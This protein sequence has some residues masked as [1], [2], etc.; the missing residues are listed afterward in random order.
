MTALTFHL[1]Q[2]KNKLPQPCTKEQRPGRLN[3]FISHLT[4]YYNTYCNNAD[5]HIVI[6]PEYSLYGHSIDGSISICQQEWKKLKSTLSQSLTRKNCV[7]IIGTVMRRKKVV[8]HFTELK[9]KIVDLNNF[10][11]ENNNYICLVENHELELLQRNITIEEQR[12]K[13]NNKIP[14]EFHR[15]DRYIKHYES[16]KGTYYKCNVMNLNI[17]NEIQYIEKGL[18]TLKTKPDSQMVLNTALC[19][20]PTGIYKYNKITNFNEV[21]NTDNLLYMPGSILQHYNMLNCFDNTF[22]ASLEICMDHSSNIRKKFLDYKGQTELYHIILSDYVETNISTYLSKYILHSS[23]NNNEHGIWIWNGANYTK[24]SSQLSTS[25]QHPWF[26]GFYI[27]ENQ[28]STQFNISSNNQNDISFDLFRK[29]F[30]DF[31]NNQN[32]IG[33]SLSRKNSFDFNNNQNNMGTSF[34]PKN[35]FDFNNNQNNIGFSLSRK[36]SFDFN[37]NQN[38][39]GTSFSPKNSFDFNNNQNNIDFSLSRKNSFDFDNNQNNMGPSFSPKNSFDFNNNQNNIDFSLSRKNSFDFNNNQNNMGTS[40]SPKNSFDFNNN[41]NNIDFS[42][43]RKNSFDFD[44]NQNNM[45][46]SFSPKNSFDFNN[47][48]NNIDFSLSRKNSFDFNNNQNNMGPSFSPK[49]SFNN[50]CNTV[51]SR[52]SNMTTNI[53]T[54]LNNYEFNNNDPILL[55]ENINKKRSLKF[56]LQQE[57]AEE[58]ASLQKKKIKFTKYS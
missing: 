34:S 51:I 57:S 41:Q 30:S 18:D 13:N 6:L 17:Q 7:F 24:V 52:S 14:A 21:D 27:Q 19:I 49:N 58:L 32:N 56:S 26:T 1:L 23:T 8:D 35:S 25:L 43:S 15:K 37:N 9:N 2:P 46:P 48:Q 20:L 42:L 36:N 4:S 33:F 40:F 39:M 53:F 10:L 54:S 22:K 50:L 12:L 47:N 45:G 55:L 5:N 3:E 11:D 38:N 44:N 16:H 31:N 28:I 29:S